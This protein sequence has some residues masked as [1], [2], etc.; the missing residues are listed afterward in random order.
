MLLIRTTDEGKKT[1][2]RFQ[3]GKGGRLRGE[4]GEGRSGGRSGKPFISVQCL[5]WP[6]CTQ[7]TGGVSEAVRQSQQ[8]HS[9]GGKRTGPG[10][11]EGEGCNGDNDWGKRGR[12]A[13]RHREKE[14]VCGKSFETTFRRKVPKK[15]LRSFRIDAGP[16][17]N[18]SQVLA[19]ILNKGKKFKIPRGKRITQKAAIV[20]EGKREKGRRIPSVYP[21]AK[22]EHRSARHSPENR[23]QQDGGVGLGS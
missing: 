7:I 22:E 12:K 11:G 16:G 10:P 1:G 4:G 19:G 13:R 21:F 15:L 9:V 17:G 5:K 20:D 2:E 3:V 8:H 18:T 14:R 6:E 23:L